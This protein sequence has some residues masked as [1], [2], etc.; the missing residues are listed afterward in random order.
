VKA[1]PKALQPSMRNS[2]AISVLIYFFQLAMVA[3]PD[4]YSTLVGAAVST[5]G[6]FSRVQQLVSGSGSVCIVKGA[7][8][9]DRLIW[10][11]F[12]P[13]GAL[14]ML[15]LVMKM[16]PL[17]ISRCSK[18]R[19]SRAMA[20]SEAVDKPLIEPVEQPNDDF[21]GGPLDHPRRD[22]YAGERH[23]SYHLSGALACLLLFSFTDFSEGTLRL[24][25]CVR[26]GDESVLV[27]AG[28][29]TC[30][31]SWQFPFV[32]L[33]AVLMLV[34]LG[35][36][37]LWLLRRVL[38]LS[39]RLSQWVHARRLPA[40]PILQAIKR[41]AV[42]PFADDQWHWTAVLCLQVGCPLFSTHV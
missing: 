18:I 39:W 25:N 9:M 14:M 35:T 17:L 36:V 15:P 11:L 7:K 24:L 16:L 22:I 40:H 1:L 42:E 26:I 21:E 12:G 41:H 23:S 28:A 34:P 2:G 37:C 8:T 38:P 29:N 20:A 33:L 5:I 13:L 19:A 27:Y 6:E 4:G 31:M 3:V 32:L 30:R 10:R